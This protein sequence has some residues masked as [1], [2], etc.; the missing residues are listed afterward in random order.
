MTKILVTIPEIHCPSCEKLVK[1]SIS[2]LQWIQSVSVSLPKKEVEIQYNPEEVSPKN[3]ISS[4]HEWTWYTVQE[5]WKEDNNLEENI[6]K[7]DEIKSEVYHKNSSQMI[8]I[9]IEWMHCSSCALLIEKSLKK[10]SGV[11][12]ANVN[13]SSAQAMIKIGSSVAQDQLIKAIENAWYIW[14]IQDENQK[15]DETEKRQKET[16]YRWR[17]FSISAVLSVPM[18]LFML[19]DFFPG[20]FPRSKIIMPWTAI[21]SLALTVPIQFIIWADFFKW[22]RSALKMKTFNM[23]SLIAIWT[24]VAFIFSLYNLILFIYQT[25]S[26]IGLDWEKIWNIYFEVAS[27]LIMFV[28][29]WKLLEAKA[30]WSTSQAISKLMWLASK[31]AKV[32]RGTSFVDLA[33]DQVKKWDIILVKPGEKIPIDWVIV[34]W[35]SSIDESMLTGESIP[36]EKSAWSKVFGGTINK[37]WSFEFEVTKIWNETALAQIIKLIQEA[38]WSK[39][40]I[41]WFADKIS[42]IFVPSVIV[43]AIIVFLIR[44]F[45]VWVSFATALLYFAAVIVIACPCA[46]GLATPTAL[47]V[48]TGKWAEKWILIKWWEPL[49]NLC[50]VDTVVFDKTWTITEWKPEVTDITSVDWY[51]EDFVLQIAAWLESKSEHPLAEAIV[52]YWKEKKVLFNNVLNFEAIPWKWVKWEINGQIYFLGTKT[53]LG[54]NNIPIIDQYSIEQLESEWKTVMLISTDK[55]MIWTI[56]VADTIKNTSIEAIKRL[57]AMWIQVYMMTWDNQRTAQ[58][59]ANQVW[60]DHVFAQ[61]LPENKASKIKELQ[62]QGHIVAMVGDWINDSPALTQADVGIAMWSWA[63][64]AMESGNVI[65]MKND[66]NDVITAIKLSKETVWKIKQNMFFAL[67]YNILGIPIAGWAL[68]FI[69]LTLKPEFAWLAMA[70]S[71]VSVVL[72]SLLLKFFHTHRRNWISMFAPVIMTVV[73]LWFFRNFAQI[74]SGQNLSFISQKWS[75]ALKTDLNQFIIDTPNKIWFTPWWVPKIFLETDD[76]LGWLKIA[77]WTWIFTNES[78][79][80]IGFKEAQMMK[81]ERL[82]KKAGDSLSGFFGLPSV[83]IVWILAPTNTLL[84]EVH[85]MNNEWFSWLDVQN[86]LFITQTPFEELKIFYLY[87]NDNIPLKLQNI[88]NP[89]KHTY[90]I[91]GKIYHAIYVWYDEAQMMIEEN[92]FKKKYD[93][94]TNLF[95]NDIIIAGLPKKTYTTLDMMHFVPRENWKK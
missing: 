58:A 17:K 39:A 86:S 76:V 34:S 29:L 45:L 14:T 21:I 8:S 41:Q 38:Q 28:A 57:K 19:Y 50:K 4:L 83:K 30:K 5:T 47:M 71:S 15:V 9:D 70:M 74:G 78:E 93:T 68:A 25:W 61:V 22:A 40:P 43:I 7:Q 18:I 24:W 55:E 52:K 62:E 64:V 42:G 12:N 72:N 60:I 59:I 54:E 31:T 53:L 44:F 37:L 51:D 92:L 91:D 75:P 90:T 11:Q 65:I 6:S 3:I 80:I 26:R 36:I 13:F 88:I 73:F 69:G 35:H 87:D 1:A 27:L 95:G 10:V 48:W 94:I 81:N 46:L 79:M 49:E 82:I 16:T 66:L 20:I 56:S 33:I 89:R 84:D 85:I 63:D 2:S 77:E 67:F 32:K 23:Y